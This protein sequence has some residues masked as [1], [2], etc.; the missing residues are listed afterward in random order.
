M[1]ISKLEENRRNISYM[2]F[3]NQELHI[4]IGLRRPFK[5]KVFGKTERQS[6]HEVYAIDLTNNQEY[7]RFGFAKLDLTMNQIRNKKRWIRYV[8]IYTPNSEEFESL[9]ANL[10]I[11]IEKNKSFKPINE[12]QLTF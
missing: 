2:F 4:L 6:T 12:S 1:E 9:I 3:Y 5:K 7:F 8:G 11:K 10:K